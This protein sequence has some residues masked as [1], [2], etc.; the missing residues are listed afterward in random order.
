MPERAGYTPDITPANL[1][2]PYGVRTAWDRPE[3]YW[4]RVNTEK[5]MGDEDGPWIDPA[6]VLYTEYA[7]Q[8]KLNFTVVCLRRQKDV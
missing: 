5:R 8:G 1:R 4:I 3:M 6:N 7:G 2:L